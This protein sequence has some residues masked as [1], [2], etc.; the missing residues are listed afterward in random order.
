MYKLMASVALGKINYPTGAIASNTVFSPEQAMI[1]LEMGVALNKLLDGVKVTD[2][3][4]C[5]DLIQ[6]KG[7]GGNFFD[8]M[9]VA[10]NFRDVLWLPEL[11]DRSPA[12]CGPIDKDKDIVTMAHKKW[13]QILKDAQPYRLD[14]EKIKEIDNIVEKGSK[15]ILLPFSTMLSISLIFSLSNR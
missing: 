9:Q 4:L 3:T 6:E 1:D 7:I 14:K 8:D 11:L 2:E 13:Q 12:S 5:L 10:M 15:M